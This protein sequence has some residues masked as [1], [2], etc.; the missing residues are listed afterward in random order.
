MCH[1]LVQYSFVFSLNWIEVSL[2]L[3]VEGS[4]AV[5]EGIGKDVVGSEEGKDSSSVD[6][7]TVKNKGEEGNSGGEW[8]LRCLL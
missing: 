5:G 6:G 1:Q 8:V 7:K 4:V 3:D 2:E